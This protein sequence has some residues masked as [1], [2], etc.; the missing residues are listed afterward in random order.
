MK[1]LVSRV[2]PVKIKMRQFPGDMPHRLRCC[3]YSGL[4][5]FNAFIELLNIA[6]FRLA[7]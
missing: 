4:L 2:L 6:H 7:F 3:A 1:G 5:K